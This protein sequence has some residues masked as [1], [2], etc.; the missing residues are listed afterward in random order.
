[1]SLDNVKVVVR[2]RPLSDKESGEGTVRKCINVLTPSSLSIDVKPEPKRFTYD[3]VADDSTSQ[4]ELF[5]AVGRPISLSC[6]RGYNGTIFAYGQTGAGKTFTIQGPSL[7]SSADL[8]GELRGLLPRCYEFIFEEIEETVGVEFLVS[9]S[10]LEI[11]QEQIID[12][13][14]PDSRSLSLR[15]DIKRGVYVEG[16]IEETVSNSAETF[17]LLKMGA[18]NRHVSSTSMNMESSRS[19]SVFTMMIES[20]YVE[21]GLVNFKSSRFHLIDLAGSERQKLTDAAGERIKEA[22]MINKSLSAL[23]NVIN[24]LVDISE[25]RSRH[26]HYRDSKLTFLLKD[27]LGGNSKT[28]IVAA[29]SP[30]TAFFSET[31]STL[32]FA[33][34]AK[35]IKNRA[36]VNEDTSGVIGVLK[37]EVRRLKEE[38]GRY[39]QIAEVAVTHCPKCSEQLDPST[40][41]GRVSTLAYMRLGLDR[42]RPPLGGISG[43]T[44]Q[45]I[46]DEFTPID[47]SEVNEGQSQEALGRRVLQLEMLL[48]ENLRLRL[49]NEARLHKEIG[50]KTDLLQSFETAIARY[51]KKISNDKMV[52]KFRDST[53]ARLQDAKPMDVPAEMD[54]LRQ[55]LHMVREQLEFNPSTARLFAENE[56]LKLEIEELKEAKGPDFKASLK[57]HEEFTCRLAEALKESV[58]DQEHARE[59]IAELTRYQTGEAVPSHIKARFNEKLESMTL[60]NELKLEVLQD[61]LRI[62]QS[63]KQSQEA[64]LHSRLT[65]QA[66][67]IEELSIEKESLAAEFKALQAE[68]TTQQAGDE[69]KQLETF[70]VAVSPAKLSTE[71]ASSSPIKHWTEEASSSPI[72]LRTEEASSSPIRL[73]TDD[74]CSSPVRLMTEDKSSS[75]AL[76]KTEEASSSPIRLRTQEASSSPPRLQLEVTSCRSHSNISQALHLD[77]TTADRE[78]RD[79]SPIK[80]TDC[81]SL[82]V[83]SSWERPAEFSEKGSSPIKNAMD[84]QSSPI[85]LVLKEFNSSPMKTTAS[86][87]G[88]S[89]PPTA[90]E[91][92]DLTRQ[93]QGNYAGLLVFCE[94]LQAELTGLRASKHSLEARIAELV[95]SAAELEADNLNGF[96]DL[97]S[98]LEE[99]RGKVD[100]HCSHISYLE[101]R[102]KSLEQAQDF[103]Q[104]QVAELQRDN[105]ELQGQ[106]GLLEQA[107]E[108]AEGRE[109][110]QQEAYEM[111]EAIR[112][113]LRLSLEVEEGKSKELTLALKEVDASR[114]QLAL[115]LDEVTA[116]T[117]R[118]RADLK[119]ALTNNQLLTQELDKS[120]KAFDDLQQEVLSC[121]AKLSA[122][123]D[124]SNKLAADRSLKDSELH[125]LQTKLAQHQAE[126]SEL[127]IK[128]SQS[129]LQS[130][131]E[132][133]QQVESSRLEQQGKLMA[134]QHELL[135]FKAQL[136]ES[137][138][139]AELL[140]KLESSVA[141]K[142]EQLARMDLSLKS[143][144]HELG[145]CREDKQR[146]TVLNLKLRED[147]EKQGDKLRKVSEQHEKAML[148]VEL[149]SEELKTTRRAAEQQ[150][151]QHASLAA[152]HA[153][154][155][156]ELLQLK[157]DA[158][159]RTTRDLSKES[160]RTLE[161]LKLELEAA[162]EEVRNLREENRTKMEILQSTN[163]NILSTRC[164]IE[165]WKKCIDDNAQTISD[166][167]RDLRLKSEE[168][169]T[170]QGQP[171]PAAQGETES[172]LEYLKYI[173]QLRDKELQEL[174]GQVGDSGKRSRSREDSSYLRTQNQHLAEELKR[175]IEQTD[176]LHKQLKEVKRH[177]DG[178]DDL[179]TRK[180][181]VKQYD[182]IKGLTEGLTRIA[183][184]VFSLPMASF[185]PEETS[186]VEGT[187]K[188]ISSLY[189]ALK[190]KDTELIGLESELHTKKAKLRILENEL[191]QR[192]QRAEQPSL[193]T[194]PSHGREFKNPVSR[195]HALLDASAPRTSEAV[196][197]KGKVGSRFV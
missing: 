177:R 169:L 182:E 128:L 50:D 61:E 62:L 146:L 173:L 70:E 83:V 68:A 32:K 7:D 1:M 29:I 121:K 44:S 25:G 37:D 84:S 38:M 141:T 4:S 172:E 127:S 67:R 87:I 41:A 97:Q 76:L 191:L 104:D 186:I 93:V 187:I 184:F 47:V 129:A 137:A 71:G 69:I 19:H 171:Q 162:Q 192:K 195:Y 138:K 40:P 194:N 53:I 55:E 176:A 42:E 108:E 80:L 133:R 34:R 143:L 98:E 125:Q 189:E 174:K 12:L 144:E 153:D 57:E 31:L 110:D 136:N 112:R 111:L 193:S 49:E 152:L 2:V 109:L 58:A 95:R 99:S 178:M 23:G 51:E 52:L 5:D 155:Q 183:D 181:I 85:K 6:L 43:R 115:Q 134:L 124:K 36:V 11:Y 102:V 179:Q 28:C 59:A 105:H 94:E 107:L 96:A 13:L 30:A 48:E 89:P 15:E 118:V 123:K 188:G 39:K 114:D 135:G 170:L 65:L 139:D 106:I 180:Q 26:V 160:R 18:R 103:A 132:N 100:E 190:A 168:L 145:Q 74:A 60:G 131:R 122:A 92:E 196:A 16:L 81:R 154:L 33:Q 54:A 78:N 163:K 120:A 119:Q 161:T 3:Y 90:R 158:A 140:Y 27:S 147:V 164:E 21:D 20:K 149:T 17:E 148:K 35:L 130:E 142:D 156:V 22:G 10:Y 64:K 79:D 166:L 24:S 151:Q 159:K 8:N 14:S 91:A 150:Q 197:S 46:S 101:C 175:R 86:S 113:E 56:K 77:E 185:S 165:V 117:A 75:P 63:D 88:L 157:E 82:R 72:R 116:T 167:R 9:C 66:K 126:I 45:R 73:S